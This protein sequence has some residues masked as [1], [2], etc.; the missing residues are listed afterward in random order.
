MKTIIGLDMNRIFDETEASVRARAQ[1]IM[2]EASED[3]ADPQLAERRKVDRAIAVE[4]E[5]QRIVDSLPSLIAA[6]I[7]N[8]EQSL[9]LLTVSGGPGFTYSPG[10]AHIVETTIAQHNAA[11]AASVIEKLTGIDKLHVRRVNYQTE[12]RQGGF[13]VVV[14]W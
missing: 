10:A 12:G 9:I 14:N 11:V 4:Q 3:R 5:A 2:Q 1:Q 6:R 7:P 13:F 8:G